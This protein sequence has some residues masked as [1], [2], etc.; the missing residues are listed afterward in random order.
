MLLSWLFGAGKRRQRKPG[1]PPTRHR[2]RPWLEPL[3]ERT[4]PDATIPVTNLNDAGDGSLR[5]AITAANTGNGTQTINFQAGLSGQILLQTALPALQ[6][7]ITIN[8]PDATTVDV[9]RNGIGQFR[10]FD[11]WPDT[12]CTIRD[13]EV[14]HG[15]SDA[16]GGGIRNRGNALLVNLVV[17]DNYAAGDGGGVANMSNGVLEIDSSQ[18]YLNQAAH[19]G[20]GVS[21]Y[22]NLTITLGTHIYSNTAQTGG[23]LTNVQGTTQIGCESEIYG[24]TA[25]IAGGGVWNGGTFTMS[26]GLIEANTSMGDGAGIYNNAGTSTLSNISI[27]RNNAQLFDGGGFYLNAG[28]LSLDWCTISNNTAGMGGGPGGAWKAGSAYNATTNCTITDA[29]VPVS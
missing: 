12:T 20:G 7:D 15:S 19:N 25:T 1:L 9:H 4:V 2:A 26:D 6:K 11:I 16:S 22:Y 21:N 3:E 28:T 5:A 10:I 27:Q 17:H 23:G 14:S 8:G 29:I 24:N 18:I 13:L